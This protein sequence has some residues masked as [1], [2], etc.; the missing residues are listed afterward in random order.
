MPQR[1]KMPQLDNKCSGTRL[2]GLVLVVFVLSIC[3]LVA[4][5]LTYGA[6]RNVVVC[7]VVCG[8]FFII[9]VMGEELS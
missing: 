8:C 7:V 4:C 6:A 2:A 5:L 9:N 3:L 1:D